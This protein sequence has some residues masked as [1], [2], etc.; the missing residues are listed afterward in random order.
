MKNFKTAERVSTDISDNYVFT[1]SL[2]AY[3][4]A[5][6]LVSGAVLELGTGT[7][8]GLEELS[9]FAESVVSV[10]KID[11]SKTVDASKYGNV[12]LKQMKFPPLTAIEDNSFDF[13]VSFQ[14]IEHVARDKQFLEEVVRVLKPG[15]KFIATTPNRLVSL[16]RNP[17]HVRE[18]TPRQFGRLLDGY[19]RRT[20]QYGVFGDEKVMEYYRNNRASVEKITRFDILKMQWWMPRFLLRIPY[21]IL[22]RINRLRLLKRDSSLVHSLSIDDYFIAPVNDT[23]FDLFY[24]AEI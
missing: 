5:A 15:G 12:C 2:I 13:V 9:P 11:V 1:R 3:K 18:Y 14:V 16:T 4:E 22:N 23:C 19:F 6:K 21:D 17:F 24:V 7:G 20:E 10:D 8:Y